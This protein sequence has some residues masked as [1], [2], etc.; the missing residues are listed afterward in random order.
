VND[1]LGQEVK[2]G[3]YVVFNESGKG[4]TFGLVERI[5]PKKVKVLYVVG[6]SKGLGSVH[7]DHGTVTKVTAETSTFRAHQAKL[8][9][10]IMAKISRE[11]TPPASALPD[12]KRFFPVKTV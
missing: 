10:A 12:D 5:T 6:W 9:Q 2:L 8:K 11:L 1:F 7:K 4:L 3:D